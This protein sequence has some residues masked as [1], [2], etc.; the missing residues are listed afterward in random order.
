MHNDEDDVC[1]CQMCSTPEGG[2]IEVT[3]FVDKATPLSSLNLPLL[4]GCQKEGERIEHIKRMRRY[5]AGRQMGRFVPTHSGNPLAR[6]LNLGS[7][8]E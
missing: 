7:E 2:L 8:L 1:P 3:D 4:F 5:Y 6:S